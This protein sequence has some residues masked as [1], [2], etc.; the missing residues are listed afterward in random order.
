MLLAAISASNVMHAVARIASNN[1]GQK[2]NLMYKW[3]PTP[4]NAIE[5]HL[6][7]KDDIFENC[8]GL[9]VAI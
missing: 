8:I 6:Q 5:G 9:L 1:Q 4:F 3:S 7:R 2:Q